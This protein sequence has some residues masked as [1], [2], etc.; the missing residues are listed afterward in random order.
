VWQCL[1]QVFYIIHSR[2][3][4]PH[5]HHKS[6]ERR[7]AC[8]TGVNDPEYRIAWRSARGLQR[9]IFPSICERSHRCVL[10]ANIHDFFAQ[11]VTF[12]NECVYSREVSK[13]SVSTVGS[14]LRYSQ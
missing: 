5:V 7:P 9:V 2:T 14:V 11:D 3:V 6:S 10:E 12:A 8:C 1:R 4:Y 13:F